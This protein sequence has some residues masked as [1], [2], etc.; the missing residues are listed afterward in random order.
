VR[1]AEWR[2][3]EQR[4][5]R[6]AFSVVRQPGRHRLLSPTR[7]RV[8]FESDRARSLLRDV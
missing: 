6:Q 7:I 4:E 5:R 3:L 2:L 1:Q 8:H